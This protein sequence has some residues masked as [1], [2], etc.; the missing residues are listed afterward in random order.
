MLV[1]VAVVLSSLV[2][3]P[4]GAD[5]AGRVLHESGH[6]PFE[7]PV[8]ARSAAALPIAPGLEAIF[9]DDLPDAARAVVTEV[10]AGFA[11]LLAFNPGGPVRIAI[12]WEDLSSLGIGGPVIVTASGSSYPAALADTLFG[13]QHA[14]GGID[15]FVRMSSSQPWSFSTEGTVPDG[16]F[17]FGSAFAHELVHA[18][19]FAMQTEEADG[20]LALSG[21]TPQF[22]RLLSTD[23]RPLAGLSRTEQHDAF[24]DDEIWIDVGGG[25]LMPLHSDRGRGTSHFGYAL[26]VADDQPG[27]LMYPGLAAGSRLHVDAPVLGVLAQIGYTVRSAPAVPVELHVDEVGDRLTI[28]WAVDLGPAVALPESFRIALLAGGRVQHQVVA[29]GGASRYSLSFDRP[30]DAVAVTA[31]SASGVES[32]AAN[33]GLARIMASAT[34]LAQ[35]IASSDYDQQHGDVLRLYRAFFN[36][37]PDIAG[38]KYWISVRQQ[39]RS[40]GSIARAFAGSAEF[41]RRHGALD[42]RA[43]LDVIY[44]NVLG[45]DRDQAGLD[46]WLGRLRAGA[47]RGGVVRWIA[48]APEFVARH[49]Y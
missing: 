45:R 4:S 29:P 27:A 10:M 11:E 13:G 12:S 33:V 19:G 38:A 36:R 1:A 46:Y 48:S 41:R 26:E 18:L 28:D 43:F 37:E 6:S 16:R 32:P 8:L 20:E 42:D 9:D 14:V 40:L 15:G 49:P 35:L 44:R 25:R 21:R 23:G 3:A 5:P 22:D 17:D 39:G 7:P 47:D 24:E 2:A 31:V 34:T 30:V